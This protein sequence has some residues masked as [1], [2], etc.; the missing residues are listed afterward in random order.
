MNI[1]ILGSG[2][3]EHALAW[4]I[5]QSRQC[6]QLFVAPGNAGTASVAHNVTLFS[7]DYS[8]EAFALIA[9]FVLEEGIQLLVVGPEAPLVAGIRDYFSERN[10]LCELLVV[11]PDRAGAQLEGSK[12]HAKAFMQRHG[13]PTAGSRTFTADQLDEGLS[14]LEKLPLPIVL[15]ADGLA[16][17]KGVI[18]CERHDEARRHLRD[19]LEHRRFGTASERVVVEE[20]LSGI[21]LSAFVLTDGK[22][23]RL[24]PAAKDYKR[25]GEGDTG[26]NTGGMGAV[27][28]VP[29][30]DAEFMQKVEE[31]IVRPTV[32][33][34]QQE[35][36][37]YRGF[38]FIGLMNVA[39]EPFV[40]EYNVR[41]G[42]PETEVIVPRIES[43]LVELLAAAANQTLDTAPLQIGEQAAAT[44]VMVAEGYPGG[45]Q[46]GSIISGLPKEDDT[47][48]FHAGTRLEG[49]TVLTNGG[50]VLAVTARGEDIPAAL[51]R[52]YETVKKIHWDGRYYRSDIGQDLLKFL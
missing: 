4:K 40:I 12:H 24:L 38:L 16:A 27:S 25:I 51:R 14:Y 28:P 50:R 23:Y 5:R 15:K 6:D 8:E 30:A 33:G 17:G 34:L 41:L 36:V 31:R 48:V 7:G 35:G 42:D 1:L 46:K 2:G 45:Y 19:M 9:T 32:D 3:R 26:P 18:I 44:V 13:I 20:F 22:H 49:E 11:G 21:E 47:L 37:D 29:F 39:G 43:D 10:D 52:S